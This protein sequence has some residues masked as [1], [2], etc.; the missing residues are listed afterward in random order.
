MHPPQIAVRR[1]LLLCTS[2]SVVLLLGT[3]KQPQPPVREH[4]G[5]ESALK[6]HGVR[7]TSINVNDVS[8]YPGPHISEVAGAADAGLLAE[9]D[10]RVLE[11]LV[12]GSALVA[13]TE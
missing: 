4:R 10:Q 11:T 1:I 7:T 8:T 9:P 2:T 13:T 6:F 5:E 3:G 12:A